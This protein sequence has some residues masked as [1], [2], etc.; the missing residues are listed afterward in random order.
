MRLHTSHP[1]ARLLLGAVF[2]LSACG[3]VT[4]TGRDGGTTGGG[5][6]LSGGGGGG[7]NADL[8]FDPNAFWAQDPPLMYCLGFDGGTPPLPGGTPDCPDDKNREGCPCP[9]V[10]MSASCW[11]GL[12]ANR[13]LGQCMD[14]MTTC[15][16]VGEL[17]QAWGPCMGYVLP[18]PNATAGAAACKC[19]S[20]GRWA[21]ANLSPCIY[22][23]GTGPGS[24]GATSSYLQGNQVMCMQQAGGMLTKPTQP[25]STDTITADCVGHFKLC[26]TLKAGDV[27]NPSANDCVVAQTCT[28]ADYTMVNMAQPFPSLPAWVSNDT[29][30][31]TKFAANGYGEMSVDGTTLTCDMV[32]EVFLRV[33]YCPSYCQNPMDPMYNAMVCAS[34]MQGGGGNF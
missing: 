11:P 9:T 20:Q 24:G 27:K 8:T 26:Y 5:E 1:G 16:K 30:C 32:K 7:G 22:D 2:L 10:G 15:N 21:L 31:T 34:C 4:R 18:D 28:E 33:G 25:F 14:G 29:A 23:S 12:R 6:D 13:N 17:S 19:F 3:N